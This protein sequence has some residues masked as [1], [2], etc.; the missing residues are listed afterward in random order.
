DLQ[1]LPD[2]EARELSNQP[3]VA[4]IDRQG[5]TGT[6]FGL[7]PAAQARL[8]PR[9]TLLREYLEVHGKPPREVL[10]I[11]PRATPEEVAAA[12]RAQTEGFAEL[13]LGGSAVGEDGP[14]K[15]EALRADYARAFE[16]L[17]DPA[18]RRGHETEEVAPVGREADPLGAEL[19]YGE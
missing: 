11:G 2:D 5:P 18:T 9:S 14:A 15:L 17:S 6:N 10:G 3:T 4:G 16:A 1:V 8:E 7:G 13:A 12:Q 19:A